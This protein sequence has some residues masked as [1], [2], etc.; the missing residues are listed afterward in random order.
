MLAGEFVVVGVGEW[1][2]CCGAA[3]LFCVVSGIFVRRGMFFCYARCVYVDDGDGDGSV[4]RGGLEFVN[5]M[6]C[7]AARHGAAWQ[8]APGKLLLRA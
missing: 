4:D 7:M 2:R 1:V 8:M 3:L 5:G 6:G